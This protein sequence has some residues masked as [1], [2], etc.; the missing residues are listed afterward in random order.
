MTRPGR[1][2]A[3]RRGGLGLAWGGVAGSLAAAPWLW[4]HDGAWLWPWLLSGVVLGLPHGALDPF[5]PARLHGAPLRAAPL[6]AFCALYL[7]VAAAVVALW[8]LAPGA[9]TAAF[10]A[11][12]WAH[13]GQGDV[14]ALRA[15]GWDRHLASTPQLVLAGVVRG[16][17]PMAVP[18]AA[19]PEATAAVAVDLV[20]VF[21]PALRA[22]SL[23]ALG[24]VPAGALAA[25]LVALGLAY[26][27]W[28]GAVVV[29]ARRARRAAARTLALDLGEVAALAFFFAV[30]PPVWSVGVYFCLWHA[31]RHLA[32]LEPLVA[33]RAPLRLAALAA[34]ATLGALALMAAAAWTL[35]AGAP[36]GRL[37]FYLVCIAGLTVPHTAL[38]AWM[39]ARQGTWR[40]DG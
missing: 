1:P 5:V 7:G 22:P 25:A 14:F 38:V 29:R 19:Q 2:F 28:G 4:A 39:D 9:A 35:R 21:D 20:A 11:L 10:V 15:L 40:A 16:A 13:W 24:A 18:F 8:G 6:A 26:A 12:T 27:V 17:L 36:G 23:A 31:V 32:R 33:P 30:L 37:A 3:W 34:P